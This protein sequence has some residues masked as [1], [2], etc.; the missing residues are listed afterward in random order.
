MATFHIKICCSDIEHCE[1]NILLILFLHQVNIKGK[2]GRTALYLAA[3]GKQTNK[4][5]KQKKQTNKQTNKP[6]VNF[7]VQAGTY[8]L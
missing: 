5:K 7:F 6:F 1:P 4:Q 8:S 2:H 3:E